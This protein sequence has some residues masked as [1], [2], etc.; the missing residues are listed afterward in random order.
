MNVVSNDKFGDLVRDVLSQNVSSSKVLSELCDEYGRTAY[1][2]AS[3]TSKISFIKY[4]YFLGRYE[5]HVDRFEHKSATSAIYL[6]IDHNNFNSLVAIKFM[7]LYNNYY[8]EISLRDNSQL[9][10]KF[11]ISIIDK[12]DS[13]KSVYFKEDLINKGLADY[14]YAIIMP[15]LDKNLQ[16]II[17]QDQIAG[18][19]FMQ[20]KFI[21]KQIINC[22]QHLHNNGIIHGDLKP[23]NI[24]RT[25]NNNTK[26]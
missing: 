21:F 26:D 5:F 18:S 6:A 25:K 11:I 8:T 12:L 15:A 14:N 24:M 20:I 1:D 3:K 19:D 7:K 13:D 2:I 16:R 22:I 23:L 4:I 10:D 9:S 17:D